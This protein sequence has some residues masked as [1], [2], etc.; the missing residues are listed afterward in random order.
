MT[1]PF[2]YRNFSV[3]RD[4]IYQLL[5]LEPEPLVFCSGSCL[6]YQWVQG[7]SLLCSIRFSISGFT[8]RSLI[9]LDL[10]FLQGDK[11]GSICILILAGCQ[12]NQ[13]HLL[14]M[15]SFFFFLSYGF[16][17]LVK[18]QVS[19]SVWVYFWVF[20]LILWTDLSISISTSCIFYY[21]CSVVQLEV[22][23]W[24]CLQKFFY[25]SGLF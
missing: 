3:S 1:E 7:Y 8:L 9:H 10:S 2:A 14:R 17:F 23:R 15:L 21:I 16:S 19:I 25:C 22:Q 4:S 11:Y 18:S 6:L 13:H 12:L 20:N 24:W 5:I